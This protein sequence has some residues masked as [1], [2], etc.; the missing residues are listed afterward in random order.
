M[1]LT[2]PPDRGFLLDYVCLNS[3]GSQWGKATHL[4]HEGDVG[5]ITLL[6]HFIKGDKPQ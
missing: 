4:A 5:G 3:Y 6:C 2:S 1:C